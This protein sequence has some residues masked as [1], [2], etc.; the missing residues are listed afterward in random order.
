MNAVEISLSGLDVEWQRLQ[1][2]AQNLANMNSTRTATG[3]VYR[4]LRL[5]S[6][7]DASFGA[8]LDA[9][10]ASFNAAGVQVMGIEP[11]TDPVRRS[12]EPGHP[13]ADADGF[14]AYPNIDQAA[15]M[16]LMIRAS[17]AYEANLAAV[18][19]AHEMYGHALNLGRQS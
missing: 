2:V 7:P 12:Y 18:S 19:I 11:Q 9:R 10:L 4:P 17:R 8:A 5:V 13:H 16:T 3:D 6:G 1:I 14:V 15:E